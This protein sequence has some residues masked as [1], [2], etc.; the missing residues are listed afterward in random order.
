MLNMTKVELELISDTVMHLFS[1]KGIRYGVSYISKRY[2]KTNN[3]YLKSFDPKQRTKT[4]LIWLPNN[5]Y[6][7]TVPKFLPKSGFKWI[8]I[9]NE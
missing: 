6:G 1:E 7:Y 2:S 5:L 8:G 4:N 3:E 9:W